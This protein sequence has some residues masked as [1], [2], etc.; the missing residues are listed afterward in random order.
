M[1]T[2]WLRCVGTCA[3]TCCA[4]AAGG[5]HM[6]H[7][8]DAMPATTIYLGI[9]ASGIGAAMPLARAHGPMGATRVVVRTAF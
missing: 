5:R 9:N 7:A 4:H 6:E 8:T 2:K 3:A 1:A